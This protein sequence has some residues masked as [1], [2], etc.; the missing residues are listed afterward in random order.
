MQWRRS[1]PLV[2]V[3]AGSLATATWAWSGNGPGVQLA[4]EDRIYGGGAL[5]PGCFAPAVFC[6][7]SS[8]DISID[9]R[10]NAN[11]NAGY[12]ELNLAIVGLAETH[13]HITC[14]AVHGNKATVSGIV[15][16]SSNAAT[17][18]DWATLFF[19]DRGNP[20]SGERDLASPLYIGL[21]DPV[22]N[23]P[24][25]P[26]VCVSPETGAPEFGFSPTYLPLTGGDL[27]VQDVVRGN[28]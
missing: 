1:I 21:P 27:V 9:A 2:L 20:A 8:R 12:G 15:D 18:G 16:S 26:Y 13:L 3:L 6:V 22:G 28:G 4:Q 25:Y 19:V 5:G 17:V 10:A 7:P 23:P 14:L 24:G 11:G